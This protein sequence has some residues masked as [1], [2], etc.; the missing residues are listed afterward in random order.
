MVQVKFESAVGGEIDEAKYVLQFRE[1]QLV[2]FKNIQ[3]VGATGILGAE[4]ISLM[5]VEDCSFR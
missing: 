1:S 2:A 4:L 3:F 5:A